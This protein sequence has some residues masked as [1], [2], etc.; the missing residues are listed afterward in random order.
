V[1]LVFTTSQRVG[2]LV[3]RD[4]ATISFFVDGVY[5]GVAFRRLPPSM[6]VYPA[7]SLV[8][9]DAS[10]TLHTELP[11]P[12]ERTM[13]AAVMRNEM[14]SESESDSSSDCTCRSGSTR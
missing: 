4:A 7:V 13:E 10:C 1:Q 14:E 11:V 6:H 8:N 2:V 3:D 12:D 5:G 9:E